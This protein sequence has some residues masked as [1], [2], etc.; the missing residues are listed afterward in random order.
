VVLELEASELPDMSGRR[1]F[2]VYKNLGNSFAPVY[3]S[4]II[5]SSS[6]VFAWH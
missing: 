3:K 4:E 5:Q 1:F 2:I 6:N